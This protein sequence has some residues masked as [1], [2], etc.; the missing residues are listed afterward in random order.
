MG[1]TMA[2][3][4]VGLFSPPRRTHGDEVQQMWAKVLAEPD[5]VTE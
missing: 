3:F 2:D 1:R 5:R 4:L